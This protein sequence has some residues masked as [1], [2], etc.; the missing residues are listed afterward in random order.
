MT[1]ETSIQALDFV[2]SAGQ[3]LAAA[4]DLAVK[5]AADAE[6]VAEIVPQRVDFLVESGLIE[7]HEKAAAAEQL[8][9][10]EGALKVVSNLNNLLVEQKQAFTQ[11][12][13]AAGQGQTVPAA[14]QSVPQTKSADVS[15]DLSGGGYVGRRRGAGE[16]SAADRAFIKELG[17]SGRIN[18]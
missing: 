17:L 13:A 7:E 14:G 16:K 2:D 3:A 11:K 5:S 18:S 4:Q 9:S 12:L 15:E 1:P 6:K 10:H 8:S